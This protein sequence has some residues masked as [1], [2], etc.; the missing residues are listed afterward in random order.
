MKTTTAVPTRV[1]DLVLV[2]TGEDIAALTAIA[3]NAGALIFRSAPT[4]ADDGRQR[5]FLRLHLHHR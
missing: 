3:R 1:L 2:G 4:A 5:V